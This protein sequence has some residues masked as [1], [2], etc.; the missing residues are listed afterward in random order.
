MSRTKEAIYKDQR[1]KLKDQIQY[2]EYE[3]DQKQAELD[4]LEQ[5]KTTK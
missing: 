3:I 5:N 4:H 2:M 1:K